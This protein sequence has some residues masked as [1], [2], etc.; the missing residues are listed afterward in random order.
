QWG[1]ID[2]SGK[3]VIEAKFVMV[4]TFSEGLAAAVFKDTGNPYGTLGYIDQSGHV[5]IPPQFSG[6]EARERGFSEGLA[7]VKVHKVK[8]D[9]WGYIDKSGKIMIEPQFADARP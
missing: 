2:E 1:F 7:A 4:K 8:G 3:Y 5:V 9:K 6:D